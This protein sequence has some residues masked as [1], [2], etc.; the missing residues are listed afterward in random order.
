LNRA[1]ITCTSI[2]LGVLQPEYGRA[3]WILGFV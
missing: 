1:G 3:F 2:D